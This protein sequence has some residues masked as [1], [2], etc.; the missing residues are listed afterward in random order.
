[1]NSLQE[2]FLKLVLD[3][4]IFLK[5]FFIKPILEAVFETII[6]ILFDKN[7]IIL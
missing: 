5:T 2:I 6:F 7:C 1:M 3:L 4:K